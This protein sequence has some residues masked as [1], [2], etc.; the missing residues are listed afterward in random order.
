MKKYQVNQLFN[1]ATSAIETIEANN[2]KQAKAVWQD[3]LD[4]EK[5][6]ETDMGKTKMSDYLFLEIKE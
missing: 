1:G 5:S 6:Q 2:I 4:E 3:H